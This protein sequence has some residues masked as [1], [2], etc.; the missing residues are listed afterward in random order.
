MAGT[1]VRVLFEVMGLSDFR[2]G[3]RVL[4]ALAGRDDLDDLT[5]IRPVDAIF[6]F[7]FRRSDIYFNVHSV[8]C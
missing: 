7:S 8:N 3:V 5:E 6:H 4:L 1:E 2:P